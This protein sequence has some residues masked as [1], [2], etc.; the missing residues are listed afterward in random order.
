[1]ITEA[2][3]QNKVFAMRLQSGQYESSRS[4]LHDIVTKTPKINQE[5]VKKKYVSHDLSSR[6]V[7]TYAL[8]SINNLR[9]YCL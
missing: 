3:Q 5:W 4:A 2:F 8:Y 9:N 7:E 1:M 6:Q